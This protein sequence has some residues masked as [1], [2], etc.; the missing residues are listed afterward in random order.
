[1]RSGDARPLLPTEVAKDPDVL[2]AH[3]RPCEIGQNDRDVRFMG[4]R[5][6]EILTGG[7]RAEI[8]DEDLAL[9]I[10]RSTMVLPAVVLASGPFP[11][12]SGGWTYG[13]RPEPSGLQA[14]VATLYLALMTETCQDLAG[15]SGPIMAEGP[16]TKKPVLLQRADHSH[17]VRHDRNN[18]NKRRRRLAGTWTSR[19][20]GRVLPIRITGQSAHKARNASALCGDLATEDC[21]TSVTARI[22]FRSKARIQRCGGTSGYPDPWINRR[23]HYLTAALPNWLT[24]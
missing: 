3:R 13:V 2:P 21:Q 19:Q 14:A 20:G 9:T 15:T 16:M 8:S 7:N 17:G 4:G 18:G 10:D 23:S 24:R 22:G 1:M 11:Q 6:F 5:E 12:V